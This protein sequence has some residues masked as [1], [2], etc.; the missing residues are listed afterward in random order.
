[1][2]E[3]HRRWQ[4]AERARLNPSRYFA[5]IVVEILAAMDEPFGTVR[6]HQAAVLFADIV[7]FTRLCAREAPEDVFW[8]LRRF[9]GRMARQ[10]FGANGTV[11]NVSA[12]G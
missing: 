7:D 4:A 12:R 3:V 10:V 11:D 5:P 8:L 6:K 1:M 2:R 9:F